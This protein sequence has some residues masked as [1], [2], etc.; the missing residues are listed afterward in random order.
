M[1]IDWVHAIHDACFDQHVAF[2][3]KQWGGRRPKRAGRLLDGAVHDTIPKRR[4]D[5]SY[6]IRLP[7]ENHNFNEAVRKMEAIP[8]KCRPDA[9]IQP[10]SVQRCRYA[11]ARMFDTEEAARIRAGRAKMDRHTHCHVAYDP[12]S[13]RHYLTKHRRKPT[14]GGT[15]SRSHQ[16]LCADGRWRADHHVLLPNGQLA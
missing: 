3:F 1:R 9:P 2:F 4:E 8:D 16:V 10:A 6:F 14:G 15:C 13:S 5:G 11:P 12:A 7:T